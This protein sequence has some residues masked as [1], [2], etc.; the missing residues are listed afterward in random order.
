MYE[1]IEDYQEKDKMNISFLNEFSCGDSRRSSFWNNNTINNNFNF[2]NNNNNI[3]DNIPITRSKT[4]KFC[5][6][7]RFSFLS[8]NTQSLVGQIFHNSINKFS[9][10]SSISSINNNSINTI[11]N[12]DEFYLKKVSTFKEKPKLDSLPLIHMNSMKAKEAKNKF[13]FFRSK[14]I[15][16]SNNET[17]TKNKDEINKWLMRI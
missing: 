17:K 4:I 11:S 5:D 7:P 14:T 16:L 8:S 13:S 9:R 6:K 10:M 3:F 1:E 12:V 15:N 2:D